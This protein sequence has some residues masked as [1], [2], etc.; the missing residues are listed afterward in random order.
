M[1]GPEVHIRNESTQYT[2]ANGTVFFA[3][4]PERPPFVLARHVEEVAYDRQTLWA[5]GKANPSREKLAGED[6]EQR[7]GPSEEGDEE[8]HGSELRASRWVSRAA[9]HGRWSPFNSLAWRQMYRSDPD[10]GRGSNCRPGSAAGR[11][12]RW[13]DVTAGACI[14]GLQCSC[15]VCTRACPR[16]VPG[17]VGEMT[18]M[19]ILRQMLTS[20]QRQSLGIFHTIHLLQGKRPAL[21][22][23]ARKRRSTLNGTLLSC[24]PRR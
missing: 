5:G 14:S 20:I 8:C 17:K 24:R 18:G 16:L 1:M 10:H 6:G 19:C 23:H 7:N 15:I 11:G 9:R 22:D 21:R 13:G 3:P 2:R 4:L 12:D